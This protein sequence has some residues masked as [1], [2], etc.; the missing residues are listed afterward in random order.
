MGPPG[1][2]RCYVFN[3]DYVDRGSWGLEV[4]LL[5]AAWKLAAPAGSVSMLRGNHE[6][7]TCTLIYGFRSELAA[8]YGVQAC[9]VRGRGGGNGGGGEG[10]MAAC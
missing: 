10:G 2:G 1:A 3:G 9:K 5:L 6:S 4:L 7:S 8:K